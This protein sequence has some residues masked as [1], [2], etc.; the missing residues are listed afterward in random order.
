MG[1][2]RQMRPSRMVVKR[3]QP[4][5]RMRGEGWEGVWEGV[6]VGVVVDC[7][8]VAVGRRRRVRRVSVSRSVVVVGGGKS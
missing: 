5:V 1:G 4:R 3:A 2:M 8:V 6:G 7:E